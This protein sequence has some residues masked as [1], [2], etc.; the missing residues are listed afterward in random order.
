M[1]N[2]EE[3]FEKYMEIIKRI[4]EYKTEMSKLIYLLKW[5]HDRSCLK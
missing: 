4:D 3:K 1:G 5:K 2:L